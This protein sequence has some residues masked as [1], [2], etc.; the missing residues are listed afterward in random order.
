MEETK[1]NVA[2]K[3]EFFDSLTRNNKKIRSDR[4]ISIAEDAQLLY[5]R[6]IEDME[7][8]IKRLRRERSN[9]L[10]LSPTDAN[11]LVLASDFDSESFVEKDIEIGVK[12]RNLEIKLDIAVERYSVLFGGM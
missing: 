9:M 5:K 3:G 7:M 10:D 8:Q 1:E 11:S 12:L 6:K 4:A 2:V